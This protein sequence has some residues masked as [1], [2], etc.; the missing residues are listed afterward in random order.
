MHAFNPL[1]A[2]LTPYEFHVLFAL[3]HGPAHAYKIKAQIWKDTRGGIQLGDSTLYPLIRR[4]SETGLIELAGQQPTGTAGK[5]PA[6]YMLGHHGHADLR[7]ELERLQHT[8]AIAKAAGLYDQPVPSDVDRL[9][10]SL[11]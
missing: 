1:P 2:P 6:H 3:R 7:I 10:Q 11:T 8:V 5:P 4:M 9:L